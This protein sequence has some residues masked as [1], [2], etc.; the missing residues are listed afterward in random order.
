MWDLAK[1]GGT[2]HGSRCPVLGL[3]MGLQSW[4]YW[5]GLGAAA[6]EPMMQRWPPSLV[7]RPGPAWNMNTYFLT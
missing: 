2:G 6:A 1:A 3:G 7:A 4:N 5:T